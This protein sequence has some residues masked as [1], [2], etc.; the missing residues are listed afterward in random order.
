MS[1]GLALL[2]PS[3]VATSCLIVEC[4]WDTTMSDDSPTSSIFP[5]AKTTQSSL[6]PLLSATFIWI[7]AE[8]S[9]TLQKCVATEG[10]FT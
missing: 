5:A 6:T 3:V 1:G 2:C 8:R 7:T 4:I 9:H 10:R